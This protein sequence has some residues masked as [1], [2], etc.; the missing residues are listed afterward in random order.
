MKNTKIA[1]ILKDIDNFYKGSIKKYYN[2]LLLRL[3]QD[4]TA[5]SVSEK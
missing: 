3:G 4:K 2:S 5:S 1:S